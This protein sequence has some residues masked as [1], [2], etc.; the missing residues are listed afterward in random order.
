[1]AD[2]TGSSDVLTA[3]YVLEYP[4]HRSVGR[5]VGEF[6][7]GLAER[8][9]LGAR[10]RGGR[11]I[12]PPQEYDPDTGEAIAELVDVGTAGAVT[13]WTWIARPRKNHPLQRPFAF[14]LVRL[15]GADTAML[16]AVDAGEAARMR[17]GMRVRARWRDQPQGAITDIEC[18]E[19]EDA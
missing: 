7:G 8:R 19:P 18:F 14:A 13:S 12:V 6:L 10:T 3:P 4:Y 5:V 11:V 17:S 15:D 2:A 16:H 9:I 1:L